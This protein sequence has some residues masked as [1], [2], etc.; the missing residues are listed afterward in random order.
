MRF[1]IIGN[2]MLPSPINA[3]D[4]MSRPPASRFA[5]LHRAPPPDE[6]A[7]CAFQRATVASL[8]RRSK[9]AKRTPPDVVG[10]P[11]KPPSAA[12]YNPG[13]RMI[14]LAWIILV[15]GTLLGVV[16]LTADLVGVGAFKGFGWK[17]TLGTVV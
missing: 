17:Q 7:G 9:A 5:T 15:L 3:I 16:S 12:C 4:F 2:P 14:G 8:Q 6:R 13:A 10:R 11:M 1:A